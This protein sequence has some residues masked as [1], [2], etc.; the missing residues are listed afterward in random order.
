MSEEI[1]SAR[2]QVQ[3]GAGKHAGVIAF[4]VTTS[5][6]SG[7][8]SVP[9]KIRGKPPNSRKKLSSKVASGPGTMAEGGW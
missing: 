8:A 3:L 2:L 4:G 5:L 1:V 6:G 7:I 9:S